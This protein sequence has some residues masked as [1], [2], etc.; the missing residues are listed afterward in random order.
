MSN[1]AELEEERQYWKD[2]AKHWQSKFESAPM[3][4]A[5]VPLVP[6]S[7][8]LQSQPQVDDCNELL[9][10][11]RAEKAETKRLGDLL[12]ECAKEL[13]VEEDKVKELTVEV[14][15]QTLVA[16]HFSN[17]LSRYLKEIEKR[18]IKVQ[19]LLD[20]CGSMGL[21]VPDE[22]ECGSCDDCASTM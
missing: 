12:L 9:Q 16:T 8:Q 1:D 6:T 11:L 21:L 17:E 13:Q 19:R 20:W 4:P 18:G 5:P 15:R 10:Q 7:T 22:L 2:R 14:Q 3:E